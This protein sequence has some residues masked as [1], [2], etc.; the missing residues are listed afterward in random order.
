MAAG[1][2]I[3][4]IQPLFAMQIGRRM[5]CVEVLKVSKKIWIAREDILEI[6]STWASISHVIENAQAETGLSDFGD[7]GFEE[8]LRYW[9]EAL[10]TA[11]LTE[12]AADQH[13]DLL[14]RVLVNRLRYFR[15]IRDH[16][17]ILGEDVSDPIVIIGFPRSGT[18]VLQRMLS[19]DSSNQAT[20]TWRVF[21]PAPFPGEK[22]GVPTERIAYASAIE[23][24]IR[25]QNPALFAAHPTIADDAEEDWFLHHFSLGHP[26]NV[27]LGFLTPEY[28]N[29]LRSI[30]RQPSFDLVANML[31]YLQ[32]QDAGRRGR[33]WILK[34]PAHIGCLEEILAAHPKATFVYPR[35]DFKTVMASFCYTLESSLNG[36]LDITPEYIGAY[37]AEFWRFE[38]QRFVR[39]KKILGDRLTIYEVPYKE[40]LGNPLE[41][42]RTIYANAGLSLTETGQSEISNW[43]EQNPAGKHGKNIYSLERY[44]LSED[45][46]QR[47]FGEFE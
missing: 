30:A 37:S 47:L 31:R 11:P 19:A 21:N 22:P 15:D 41:H 33:R 25:T 3:E 8:N 46:V 32:W 7:S 20:Q 40:L 42:I 9:V 14:H 12:G 28:L 16:Q 13:F 36:S 44:G 6:W 43:I 18:T 24:A 23:D 38:M 5:K 4:N 26:A 2:N 35:R 10:E 29:R 39:A 27:C 17:E 45:D 1:L 34:S